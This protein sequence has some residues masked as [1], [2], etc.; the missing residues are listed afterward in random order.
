M[1]HIDASAHTQF[2]LGW[3][4]EQYFA[5]THKMTSFFL[6][7][8]EGRGSFVITIS[9][10]PFRPSTFPVRGLKANTLPPLR[11]PAQWAWDAICDPNLLIRKGYKVIALKMEILGI[12]VTLLA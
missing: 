4:N 6:F 3:F 5:E 2:A 7:Q 1:L 12:P 10:A 8:R 11:F 9:L